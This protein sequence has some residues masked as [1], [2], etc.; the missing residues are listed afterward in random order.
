MNTYISLV[1]GEVR[2]CRN[3]FQAWRYYNADGKI[4]TPFRKVISLKKYIEK[5]EKKALQK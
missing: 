5:Y 2:D 3:R 4:K 1:S